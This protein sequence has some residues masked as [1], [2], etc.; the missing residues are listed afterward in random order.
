MAIRNFDRQTLYASDYRNGA[1]V[2]FRARRIH[3]L[4]PSFLHVK[5]RSGFLF[6]PTQKASASR[7]S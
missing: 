4:N 7:E 1:S 2:K 3:F 5:E 6:R